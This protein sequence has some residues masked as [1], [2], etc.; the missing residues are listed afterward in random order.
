MTK[1]K[2]ATK[3]TKAK[4]T[5][6]KRQGKDLLVADGELTP[7]G[8][9]AHAAV[10]AAIKAPKEP[11]VD[12][13]KLD[14]KI[15]HAEG[16]I[17]PSNP[18]ERIQLYLAAK[19][20]YNYHKEHGVKPR[21]LELFEEWKR[22]EHH[23]LDE[24]NTFIVMRDES[25]P[26]NQQTTITT[27]EIKNMAAKRTTKKASKAPAKGAP[28]AASNGESSYVSDEM[29]VA[30]V[31]AAKASATQKEI[32]DGFRAKGYRIDGKR[33]GAEMVR[34]GRTPLG[35]RAEGNGKAATPAKPK[36]APG[37]PKLKGKA[38][39]TAHRSMKPKA[40]VKAKVTTT[41]KRAR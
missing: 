30:A 8:E 28:K 19:L 1:P 31:K 39:A 24:V 32:A 14:P 18:D 4:R 3:S 33:V 36:T 7:A 17:P 20:A 23:H 10:E 11:S 5:Q 26:T 13:P 38:T 22:I 12:P 15:L 34:Q 41:R 25:E 2:P 21:L 37:F 29:I 27:Q 9:A 40:K 35:G 6:P 16:L